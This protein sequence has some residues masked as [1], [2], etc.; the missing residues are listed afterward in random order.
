MQISVLT[1][2]LEEALDAALGGRRINIHTTVLAWDVEA[3]SLELRAQQVTIR[4]RDNSPL[5]TIPTID[6]KLSARAL[7]RGTVALTAINIE[8]VSGVL[9]RTSEGTF[10]FGAG[11][12]ATPPPEQLTPDTA[13]RSTA[14]QQSQMIADLVQSLAAD[15]GGVAPLATLHEL[16]VSK[17]TLVVHDQRLGATWRVTQFDLTLRRQQQGLTG[18]GHLT[19]ALPDALTSVDTTLAY[20]RATEK[21]ALDATFTDLRPSALATVIADAE[22]LTGL[23][24]PVNGALKL[25]LDGHGRLET[26]H[27]TLA[28]AAGSVSYPAVWP[29][30]LAVSDIMVRGHFDGTAGALNLDEATVTLGTDDASTSSLRVTGKVEGLGADVTIRGEATL[31]ALPIATLKRLWPMQVGS[32][33]RAWVSAQLQAGQVDNASANV[34]LALP[35]GHLGQ[36]ALQHLE[37]TLQAHLTAAHSTARFETALAYSETTQAGKLDL[38]FTDLRPAALATVVPA[39]QAVAGLDV[40]LSGKLA[41]AVDIHGQWR[42]LRF[43]L[44]GGPGSFSY[45][46]AFPHA[47]PVASITVQGRLDGSQATLQLDEATVAFG[48]ARATGPRLSLSGTA[49]ELRRA[50]TIDGQVILTG[51]PIAELQDYWPAGV[52]A[53]ARAWLT[54]NL[55]AGTV[56]EAR[57]QVVVTVPKTTAPTAK[58]ERLQGTLRYQDLEVHYLRPLP[59]ATGVSG[60]AS[61]DQQGFRIQLN[62]GQITDMHITGGTVDITGLDRGRDAMAIHVGV[63]TPLRTVLTLLNHPHLNLLADFG[64]DPATTSGQATVQLGLAFSLRGQILLP[65]VDL[66][67]HGTLTEVSVQQ[68]FLG[69]NAEHGH[70][71]LDLTKA[72]MTLAGT[73]AFAAIPLTV[74]WQEAFNAEAAWKRDIRVTAA[75]LDPTQLATFGLDV[76]DF[77]AGPLAA[78][79][80]ARFDRQGQSTVEATVNLQDAQ[81]TLP[82]LGWH[83]PAHA[84]GEAQSTVQFM[85]NQAPSQGTFRI[86]AGTLATN[87]VFH[88]SPSADA[89]FNL[90]LRDLVVDQSHFQVVTIAQRRERIDVTLGEGV[91]D[92]QPLMDALSS[93]AQ[94][95]AAGRADRPDTRPH[96]TTAAL[97]VHL[98]APALRRVSLGDDRYLQDVIATFTHGPEGWS[99]IGLAARIPEALVPRPRGASNTTDQ[100][101][102]PRTFSLQYYATAQGPYALSVQ[103]NDLGAVLSACDLYNGV[104]GGQL[105]IA[106]QTTVPRPD[107]PLQGTIEIKD[108]TVQHT[109]VL[110]RLMAAASLTGLLNTLR[111]DGL[112]FAQLLSDFTLADHVLTLRQLRTHGGALGLTAA[113]SIDMHASSV[114]LQGTIIPL[115]KV[116]TVLDKIPLVG[117]LLVGGKGQGLIA[118]ATRVTGQ[119]S[120]PQ[121]SVNPAS[122]VTP[123]FL[124]GFF[125]LFKGDSGADGK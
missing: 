90:E 83:K 2:Y 26:L 9:H 108:F 61:F 80:N 43:T 60:S 46:P 74:A 21:I 85:G 44:T 39:W 1:P 38:S 99:A 106:G 107:G 117:D 76:T 30:P 95:A 35:G 104:I 113:G 8:E 78:M 12:A 105:T 89:H 58:L 82:W 6:V 81:L 13:E 48:T 22:M 94:D 86:H 27:F 87:G 63:D 23:D 56:E 64:I 3:K 37:G 91:L 31:T 17:G 103:T 55:V 40:P 57:A 47:R 36:V 28:S 79:L 100:A 96:D 123:G 102:Q 10:D 71:T 70:L 98:Q 65:K 119:L 15:P 4:Q 75:R 45:A 118:I 42:D 53:D 121:V 68:A 34:V 24:L 7:L 69:H 16:R 29:E 11:S 19:L 125:D 51:L 122:V 73:V 67:V 50:F 114:D 93:Q 120:D 62:A 111:S 5:A 25:T 66:T 59:P 77:V 124:R 14:A 92:A 41:A 33:A 54:E 88:F 115:Y 32:Q 116:N 101:P 109:P 84:P 18:T 97:V 20:E 72:G 110:A 52:S 112:V 49:Q